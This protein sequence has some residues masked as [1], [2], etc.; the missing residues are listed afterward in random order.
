MKDRLAGLSLTSKLAAVMVVANIL[1]IA[2]LAAFS[3]SNETSAYL[4][5][6]E[7]RWLKESEQ[8][9]S[10]AAGGIRWN[11]PDVVRDA[12]TLHR[13]DAS[14]NLV[15][16]L[17]LNKNGET[18]DSWVAEGA[19][20]AA[21]GAPAAE[22]IDAANQSESPQTVSEASGAVSIVVPLAKDKLGKIP[23]HVVTTWTTA[24]IYVQARNNALIL[25]AI[26]SV[27]IVLSLS[28]FLFALRRLIGTPLKAITTSIE[29]MQAGDYGSEVAYQQNGDEIGFVARALDTFRKDTIAKQAESE[30]AENE[31]RAFDTE[32]Q[33]NAERSEAI[34][35]AQT[36]AVSEIGRALEVVAGGDFTARLSGLGEDYEKI[37]RD[38]NRMVEAVASTLV[39]IRSTS[40]GV[41]GASGELAKSADTLAKRTEQTAAALEETAASLHEMTSRVRQSSEQTAE[42]ETMV[43]KAKNDTAASA[44]VMRNAIGAMDRIQDSSSK[45]G[46]IISVIDEI[47]FQTNLLALNAGVEAARAGDAGKGFAVVAHEVRELAQRSANAAKEISQLIGASSEQ[48]NSG[49]KLVNETGDA[50]LQIESQISDINERIQATAASYREQST[51][52]EEI[53]SAVVSM[54][55]TTQQNAAMFEE[56]NAACQDLQAQSEVL[57][58]AISRFTVPH[59]AEDTPAR[60][61][62]APSSAPRTAGPVPVVS[63]NTALAVQ[64]DDWEEF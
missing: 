17:A 46:Q 52:L 30:A 18:V 2:A 62:P 7:D 42:A 58:D 55:Q 20:D 64:Q 11:K 28:L 51:G 13:G 43:V 26:Q 21:Q 53:N 60:Q 47:A 44:E 59:A 54:D 31:R 8:F 63:G 36:D 32:R 35:Q 23:G 12:Y 45:I 24:P 29:T 14:L 6:A 49:V 4:A 34:A 56:T 1:G 39:D 40:L 50:L 9:A 19:G 41:D 33:H 16:F 37:E 57:K 48:V 25:L 10:I 38:F 27:V 3:W 5:A 61:A 22:V 15:G